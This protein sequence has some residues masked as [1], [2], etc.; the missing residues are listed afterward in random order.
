MPRGKPGGTSGAP[1]RAGRVRGEP[2]TPSN[3]SFQVPLVRDQH[4]M[5]LQWFLQALQNVLTLETVRPRTMLCSPDL[6]GCTNLMFKKCSSSF[7]A[8]SPENLGIRG[9]LLGEVEDSGDDVVASGR[10]PTAKDHAHV[11]G[12]VEDVRFSSRD[13]LDPGPAIGAGKECLDPVFGGDNQDRI[14]D[15]QR[16]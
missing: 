5:M 9:T 16:R 1:C 4:D 10:L 6:S 13:Q 14:S 8:H 3:G 15:A 2:G 12:L 11:E 7:L